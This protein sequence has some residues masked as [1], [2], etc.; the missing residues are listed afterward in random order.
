MDSFYCLVRIILNKT[1]SL[2]C[3]SLNCN[4]NVSKKDDILIYPTCF[5]SKSAY[6]T[7]YLVSLHNI[8][9]LFSIQHIGYV[10]IE[11]Y[12]AE[13]TIILNQIYIQN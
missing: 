11:L 4:I 5:T 8:S 1:I 2:Y 3:I 9:S 13:L 10:S 7:L 12:K 6:K